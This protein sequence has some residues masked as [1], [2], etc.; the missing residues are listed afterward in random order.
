MIS[1]IICVYNS[2]KYLR[3]C[4]D[5]IRK[6]IYTDFEVIIIN[7]G[8][9]DNSQVIIDE[10]VNIDSRFKSIIQENSGAALA[11]SKA[12]VESKGEY[13]VCVDP[14][15]EIREDYL[16]SL[17]KAIDKDVDI[18]FAKYTRVFDKKG[19]FLERNFNYINSQNITDVNIRDNHELLIQIPNAMHSK[20]FKKKFLVDNDILKCSDVLYVDFAFTRKA[21]LCNPTMIY[22]DNDGYIYH[23]HPG[24][25]MTG[26]GDRVFKIFDGFD[27]IV[28]FAREKNVFDTYRDE[29]EYLAF[30]HI[31][32]GTMYRSF[33]NKPFSFF[34]S[35][36]KCRKYLKKYNF[37]K[38][39]KYIRRLGVFERVY[40]FFFFNI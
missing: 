35:L 13:I 1:I 23:V 20:I 12:L 24:S 21:L 5:S 14:D 22:I 4:F 19:N 28:R 34:S 39:N 29:L 37:K 2:E 30:Y 3:R 18:G 17:S 32:I 16:L 40:L 7:D 6:Q 11:G 10:Y 33:I 31:G 26:S 25:I 8:S 9:P 38:N 27:E 15:D 36:K